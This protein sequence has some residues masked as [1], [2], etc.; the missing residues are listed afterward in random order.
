LY[1]TFESHCVFVWLLVG[2]CML[3]CCAVLA[4]IYSPLAAVHVMCGLFGGLFGRQVFFRGE[5]E[6]DQLVKIS[7]VL[8][9]DDLYAYAE[10]YGVELDPKLVQLCGYRPRQP[11]RKFINDDNAHLI[12]PD[13]LSLLSELLRYDH[14][15]RPTAAE[16]MQHSYFAPIRSVREQQQQRPSSSSSG[17]SSSRR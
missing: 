16:A 17:G 5:D 15:A 9:T 11:W 8:G 2:R 14:Q 1:I 12:T 4:C 10:K 7:K 3:P 6:L 13:A